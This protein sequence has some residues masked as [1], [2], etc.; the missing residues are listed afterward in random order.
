MPEG[1]PLPFAFRLSPLH[2]PLPFAVAFAV[3]VIP[4]PASAGEGPAVAFDLCLTPSPLS[5]PRQKYPQISQIIPSR[6]SNHRIPQPLKKRIRITPLRIPPRIE[7]RL[8]RSLQRFSI[9]H[10]SRRRTRPIHSIRTCAQHCDLPPSN[11]RHAFQNKRR[12]SPANSIAHHRRTHFSI[13]NQRHTLPGILFA[14]S[15]QLPQQIF[16]R[17]RQRPVI[18]HVVAHRHKSAR[19]RRHVR[20]MK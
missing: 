6:P 4:N 2:P 8:H 11:S 5:S 1:P 13:R 19:L 16:R 3:A 15:H 20:V 17:A 7:P 10:R 14:Q 12:I 9:R 18:R